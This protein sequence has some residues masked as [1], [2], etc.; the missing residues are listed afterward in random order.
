VS[1]QV[2]LPIHPW[3]ILAVSGRIDA[4]TGAATERACH[5]ALQQDPRLALD[6]RAV[7]YLSS[8]GLRVL[9]STLKLAAS[10]NG[11]FALIAPQEGVREVLDMSGFSRIIPIVDDTSNLA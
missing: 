2:D 8:A 5:E 9:L 6:L 11:A 7:S 3:R 1:K 10:R 4:L